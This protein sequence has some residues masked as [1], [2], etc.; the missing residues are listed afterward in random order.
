MK[1]LLRLLLVVR[2]CVACGVV[3][4]VL[5]AGWW[6]VCCPVIYLGLCYVIAVLGSCDMHCDMQ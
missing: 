1:A 4:C 3:V 6:C 2:V 5:H